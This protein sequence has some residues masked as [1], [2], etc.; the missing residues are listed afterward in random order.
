MEQSGS[1][2]TGLLKSHHHCLQ[3]QLAWTL[4]ARTPPWMKES[5]HS[6]QE[7]TRRDFGSLGHQLP[8]QPWVRCQLYP[9]PEQKLRARLERTSLGPLS[10]QS[11]EWPWQALPV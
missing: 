11:C 2:H 3:P 6:H 4:K 10:V 5:V 1:S 9:F 8:T 7:L